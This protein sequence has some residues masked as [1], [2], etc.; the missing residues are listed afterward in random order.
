MYIQ[1]MYISIYSFL[2]YKKNIFFL[3]K[4]IIIFAILKTVW[5]KMFKIIFK[6]I[7]RQMIEN[8]ILFAVNSEYLK[9]YYIECR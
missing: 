9:N 2:K 4:R 3:K 1:Y 8:D 5:I 6:L 7:S